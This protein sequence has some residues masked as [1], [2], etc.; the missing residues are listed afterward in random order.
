MKA[1]GGQQAQRSPQY[2]KALIGWDIVRKC[3]TEMRMNERSFIVGDE[4]ELRQPQNN[5][6]IRDYC[7]ERLEISADDKAH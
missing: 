2:L 4:Q 7:R 1:L 3:H 6:F 5:V